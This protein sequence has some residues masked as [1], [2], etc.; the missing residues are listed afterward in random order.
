MIK[1][2]PSAGFLLRMAC[3]SKQLKNNCDCG[4]VKIYLPCR[5]DVFSKVGSHESGIAF[6]GHA[7]RVAV[8]LLE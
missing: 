2:P 7:P 1:S 5:F 4:L 8:L 3:Q 6:A